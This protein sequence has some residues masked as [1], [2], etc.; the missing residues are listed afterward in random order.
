MADNPLDPKHYGLLGALGAQPHQNS[1]L[2]YIGNSTP[3]I[4]PMARAIADLLI[5]KSTPATSANQFSDG[6]GFGSAL[7]SGFGSAF[8]APVSETPPEKSFNALASILASAQPSVPSPPKPSGSLA[9]ILAALAPAA[10][11]PHAL[12]IPPP[13]PKPV[14]PETKRK[15][16]FSFHFDDIMR[17]NNV[18]NAWKITHA[19]S[20][21]NRSFYDSSLWET[22]KVTKPEVIQQIIRGG[23]LHTSAVCILAGSN[24][25]S[26][27]WV[28]YE[29]ARTVIDGRGLLTVHLNSIPHHQT[30]GSHERGRNPLA[31]LG[32]A[33]LQ[34]D[35]RFPPRYYLYELALVPDGYG[36]L[37]EQWT[38]YGDYAMPVK[39]PDWL[40]DPSLDHVMPLSADAAEYDYVHDHGYRNI[41]SWIDEAAKKAGR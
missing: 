36:G 16:F 35:K 11:M 5:E 12:Y 1:L 21:A 26:R 30:K 22:R 27:R 34:P 25:W 9:N 18:R 32:V 24:T 6:F 29:I 3:A 38:R 41:G 19:D 39:K 37:T 13:K 17:V 20:A 31:H 14:A 2:D 28:R 8:G 15:V 40:T 7:G 4:S 23:V 33:K 10:P